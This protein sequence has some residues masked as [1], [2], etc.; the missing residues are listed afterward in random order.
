MRQERKGESFK[1]RKINHNSEIIFKKNKNASYTLC[2]ILTMTIC[3]NE[4]RNNALNF[5][6]FERFPVNKYV[7]QKKQPLSG[8]N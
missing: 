4:N 3:I 6:H 7:N 5:L 1:K 2:I 8:K